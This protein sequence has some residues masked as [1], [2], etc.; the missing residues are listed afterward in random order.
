APPW[1]TGHH[2]AR[3]SPHEAPMLTRNPQ[4]Q[5][6]SCNSLIPQSRVSIFVGIFARGDDFW[7]ADFSP[8]GALAP[9]FGSEAKASRGLKPG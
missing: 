3:C 9:L 8:R 5:R 7:R 1:E 2:R 4:A 6:G